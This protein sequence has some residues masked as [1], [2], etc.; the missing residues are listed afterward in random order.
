MMYRYE[1]QIAHKRSRLDFPFYYLVSTWPV[2]HVRRV[3]FTRRTFGCLDRTLLTNHFVQ[4]DTMDTAVPECYGQPVS[5]LL[6]SA[7]SCV[8][9][10]RI[11]WQMER[12]VVKLGKQNIISRLFCSQEE[13]DG[14]AAWKLDL[15]R[16]LRV[17]NVRSEVSPPSFLTTRP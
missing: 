7:L 9:N 3:R 8:F 17:F 1:V 10:R 15:N 14:I 6:P 12:N 5:I 4:V 2:L 16:V 11:V 13:K